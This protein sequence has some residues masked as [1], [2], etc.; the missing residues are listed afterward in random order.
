MATLSAPIGRNLQIAS[1]AANCAPVFASEDSSV[2]QATDHPAT[3]GSMAATATIGGR[4][5][6]PG[7]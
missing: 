4:W 6:N 1:P 5:S 3:L 2:Q 7:L